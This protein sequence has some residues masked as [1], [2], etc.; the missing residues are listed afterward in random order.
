VPGREKVGNRWSVPRKGE[1]WEPL[2]CSPEG[3]RLGTAG[4]FPGREKGLVCSRKGQGWEPLVWS[5]EGRRL[6][7]RWSGPRKGEG[8][9]PLV[10]CAPRLFDWKRLR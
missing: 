8:W 3:R 5:P 7:T 6:G 1:G 4:L 9:E 10:L 2:V